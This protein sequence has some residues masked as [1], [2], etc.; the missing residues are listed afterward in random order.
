[1]KTGV[2]IW[3]GSHARGPGMTA[4]FLFLGGGRAVDILPG[5]GLG[6]ST[7][8]MS[9]G[10]GGCERTAVVVEDDAGLG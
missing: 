7:V 8:D 5:L 9:R 2:A 10:V 3:T 1:M 6:L 4:N